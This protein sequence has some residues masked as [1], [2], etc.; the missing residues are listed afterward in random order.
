MNC[1]VCDKPRI[2]ETSLDLVLDGSHFCELHY[3]CFN[4]QGLQTEKFDWPKEEHSRILDCFTRQLISSKPERIIR[5]SH[6]IGD[7]CLNNKVLSNVD[8]QN[9][10]IS[11]HIDM[12]FCSIRSECRLRALDVRG[13]LSMQNCT[14]SRAV[15]SENIKVSGLAYFVNCNFHDDAH[16][17]G[18][19]F[20][21]VL[22]FENSEFSR[23]ASF[24]DAVFHEYVCLNNVSFLG[25]CNFSRAEFK[26]DMMCKSSRFHQV[27][28]F[29]HCKGHSNLS[30]AS[31][32]FYRAP[33]F[34]G[35]ELN[36]N[37]DISGARFLDVAS[38]DAYL[39]YKRL[40]ILF[41]EKK[42]REGEL[43]LYYM[44][45]KSLRVKSRGTLKAIS[46]IYEL[47]SGYGTS[48]RRALLALLI[49][50]TAF[51]LI[52]KY[53]VHPGS[54][55]QSFDYALKQMFSPF[56]EWKDSAMN[57]TPDKGLAIKLTTSVH[58]IVNF[59]IL[60]FLTLAIR[61]RF[62]KGAD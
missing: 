53:Q 7:V 29:E 12:A 50:N 40:R 38:E 37:V 39:A 6:L 56:G 3:P 47:I 15:N 60:G 14:F 5:G 51:I 58:S 36:A 31:S 17:G 32:T 16:F 2:E 13:G 28:L 9:V 4:E 57:S 26:R 49:S 44:E 46:V 45:Q 21:N 19:E 59:L 20:K 41:S 42:T 27:T 10:F 34:S 62:S 11:G 23:Y 35:A 30:F 61:W 25:Y 43:K 24:R 55:L 54:V 1:S 33:V 18:G 8:L 22:T 52:Y 48:I